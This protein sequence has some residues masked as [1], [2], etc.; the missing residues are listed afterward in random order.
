[1]TDHPQD[2]INKKKENVIKFDDVK[3]HVI[4]C[5]DCNRPLLNVVK[6]RDSEKENRIYVKCYSKKCE[7]SSWLHE[8]RGDLF[9]AP[10]K[11]VY[12]I[13]DMDYDDVNNLM[14]IKIKKDTID[15]ATGMPYGFYDD[16]PPIPEIGEKPSQELI[17]WWKNKTKGMDMS[18]NDM[19]I[20][21]LNKKGKHD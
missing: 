3:D 18:E 14:T 6:I 13:E 5:A 17:D 15:S 10:A 8:I 21:V 19:R 2:N 11:K 9:F 7:G 1:M 4:E 12:Q 16:A 20:M